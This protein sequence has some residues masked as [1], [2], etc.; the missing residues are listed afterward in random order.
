[1]LL[2]RSLCPAQNTYVVALRPNMIVTD[3]SL[4]GNYEDGPLIN[5]ISA[6]IRRGYKR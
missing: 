3:G 4:G 2:I 6:L 5:E 1:M